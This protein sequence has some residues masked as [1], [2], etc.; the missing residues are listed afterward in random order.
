MLQA[1]LSEFG[2]AALALPLM[3]GGGF[4]ELAILFFVLAIVAAVVGMG[5]VAGISMRI[6][7]IFVLVFLILAVISLLL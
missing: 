7:K 3:L 2:I 5:G 1:Y 4:I 6:A